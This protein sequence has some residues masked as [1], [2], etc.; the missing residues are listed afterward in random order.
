MRVAD[1][2]STK[3][4]PI[5]A[6]FA[7][8]IL[9]LAACRNA[10]QRPPETRDGTVRAQ[11]I[12][13]AAGD[14]YEHSDEVSYESPAALA[15]NPLP[16]YPP[17]RLAERLPPR[18][19]RV[20]LIVDPDG[21]VGDVQALDAATEADDDAFLRSV[22]AACVQWRFSPLI[23]RTREP[24]ASTD[25]DGTVWTEYRE[26]RRALPFHLDF[27]FRFEQV[28]GKAMTVTSDA[29]PATAR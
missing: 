25:A 27:A 1:L 3:R 11:Q 14:R 6:L 16:E 4:R 5:V 7:L 26:R 18:S 29:A 21:R 8:A 23:E 17:A 20:R 2:R 13:A 24:V 12:P 19:V 10:P 22:R 9:S 15:D 28:D